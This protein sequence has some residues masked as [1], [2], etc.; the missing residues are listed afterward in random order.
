M[1]LFISKKLCLYHSLLREVIISA[2][3][4]FLNGHQ[5][6]RKTT[7]RTII[8]RVLIRWFISANG[9]MCLYVEMVRVQVCTS[10]THVWYKRGYFTMMIQ[11]THVHRTYLSLAFQLEPKALVITNGMIAP[12]PTA[13]WAALRTDYTDSCITRRLWDHIQFP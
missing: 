11:V 7:S 5:L 10:F 12:S 8:D 13:P 1:S 4:A 3:F 9:L 2:C 6:I